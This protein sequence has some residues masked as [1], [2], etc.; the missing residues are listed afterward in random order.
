MTAFFLPE[1]AAFRPTEWTRGPWDARFQHGGPPS[2]LLAGHLQRWGSDAEAWIVARLTVE[3]LR[4]VPIAATLRVQ[5]EA[6]RLG[7]AVQR[8]RAALLDGDTLLFE[9]RALRLRRG[10]LEVPQAPPPPPAW[11]DPEGLPREHFTFFHH[12]V[13]YDKAVDLRLTLG[14]WGTTPVGYW[15]RPLLPL[16]AGREASPL[17]Q[18]VTLADAQSG[19]GPPVSPF[20]Y[21]YPNPDLT[22]YLLRDPVGGWTGFDIRSEASSAAIG[23]A[24]SALRDAAGALGRSAQSLLVDRRPSSTPAR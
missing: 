2:A 5:V 10:T 11:P 13:G 6:E 24:E 22:V 7:R 16:V 4:P 23:L 1:G 17:E 21:A 8:L 3:L 20:D 18:L 19:M 9:A 15:A 14:A 12:E